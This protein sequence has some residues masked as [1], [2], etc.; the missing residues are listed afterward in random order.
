MDIKRYSFAIETGYRNLNPAG[1]VSVTGEDAFDFLQGQLSQDLRG[2]EQGGAKYGFLLTQKGRVLG[3]VYILAAATESLLAVSWSLTAEA[4]MARLDTYLIADDVELEDVTSD[5]TGWHAAGPSAQGWMKKLHDDDGT[6]TIC[7]WLEPQPL[8]P[9]SI[10]VLARNEVTWPKD[11]VE[12]NDEA[13]EYAR[14]AAG[15]PQ[16]PADLGESDFPQECGQHTVGVSFHKGCYLGQEV[17]ARLASTGRLRREL[18][19]VFGEGEIPKSE[20]QELRQE[21][22]IVGELRS[23]SHDGANGW[24]GLAMMKLAHWKADEPV[25]LA[26]SRQIEL[27]KRETSD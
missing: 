16:V 25:S 26:G 14:I 22:R 20:E 9:G 23:R 15:I 3:D 12:G 6:D 19:T 1:V 4:L 2:V 5:W 24:A 27:R 21:D 8:A 13:F 17:M 18:V 7:G 10:R 11:W